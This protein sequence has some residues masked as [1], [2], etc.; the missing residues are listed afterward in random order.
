MKLKKI[1]QIKRG[2]ANK[3]KKKL[4]SAARNRKAPLKLTAQ[5]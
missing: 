3:K 5:I 1:K 4:L 2:T